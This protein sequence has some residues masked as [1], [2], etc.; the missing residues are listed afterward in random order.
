MLVCESETS[1]KSD[2]QGSRKVTFTPDHDLDLTHTLQHT[3]VIVS[4]HFR[5]SII[6]KIKANM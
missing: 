5:G 1:K 3:M 2:Y 6:L 4:E